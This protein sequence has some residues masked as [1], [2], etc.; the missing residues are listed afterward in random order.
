MVNIMKVVIF[1]A[2]EGNGGIKQFTIKVAETCLENGWDATLFLPSLNC[3]RIPD[4]LKKNT[5]GYEKVKTIFR[6]NRKIKKIV[7]N[8]TELSP[9]VVIMCDEA[10]LSLQVNL[11]LENNI[12]K[13]FTIHDVNSHPSSINI[14]R[15]LVRVLNIYY[16]KKCLS[17]TEN[18]LLLSENGIRNFNKRYLKYAR[19]VRMLRL[20][21]HV[22]SIE[23][24]IC[25]KEI[26]A[27]SNYYLF[28]GRI[29]KYKGIARLL[30]AYKSLMNSGCALPKLVIAGRGN[31]E[32]D[33]KELISSID[34]VIIINRFIQDEE[35]CWLFQHCKA[36]IAPYIE[37]SQSG[38][39]S[40]AYAFGK[41]V[42][43]SNIEGLDEFV[44]DNVTGY[45]FDDEQ[46][47]T[48]CLKKMNNAN[49]SKAMGVECLRFNENKLCWNKNL[50]EALG[51]SE[52]LK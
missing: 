35:M 5:I 52:G 6:N 47:L 40:M 37:A 9:D 49:I 13:F 20:G 31:F 10:V 43:A 41:P 11:L 42:I 34:Q 7:S 22:P 14:R 21:A 12:K 19:K 28:F 48:Y 23:H 2:D 39:I 38:V 27:D 25:P 15:Y 33:E 17:H 46:E 29:E 50:S 16:R 4:K 8:I 26:N 3:D 32:N 18:V 44:I 45:L 24:S 51:L 36:V 1:T 30:R